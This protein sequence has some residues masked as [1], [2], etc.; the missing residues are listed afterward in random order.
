MTEPK[1]LLDGEGSELERDLLRSLAGEEPPRALTRRMR[2][3]LVVAGLLTSA[4][5]GVASFIAVAGLVTV[6]AGGG[7]LV[8]RH[9]VAAIPAPAV[10]AKPVPARV[11]PPPPVV[12]ARAAAPR[13]TPAATTEPPRPSSPTP[14][15]SATGDLREEISSMDR[16]RAAVRAG[17]GKRALAALADYQKRFPRGT[18]AQEATVLRIE[19]LVQV[20]QGATAQALGKKFLAAHPESPHAERIE[21]LLG[22]AR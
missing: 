12:D 6:S 3:G 19:A 11:T 7:W 5:T 2:Q 20:G 9:H 15:P 17:D 21:R 10:S 4:K 22:T 14:V 8:Y 18:F 16:A 13:P 1:R